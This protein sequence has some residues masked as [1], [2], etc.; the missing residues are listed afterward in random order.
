MLSVLPLN[1]RFIICDFANAAIILIFRQFRPYYLTR[2]VNSAHYHIGIF[3]ALFEVRD[4]DHKLSQAEFQL[5][6]FREEHIQGKSVECE[7]SQS[8]QFQKNCVHESLIFVME[9]IGRIV[10]EQVHPR[11]ELGNRSLWRTEIV[12]KLL[13]K[14][15][16]RLTLITI[17]LP[18]LLLRID[19]W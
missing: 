18:A 19:N 2:Q 5:D 6:Y 14:A 10:T 15:L 13:I 1:L 4:L 17:P 8:L 7:D 3:K 16:N 11:V 12:V 9:A